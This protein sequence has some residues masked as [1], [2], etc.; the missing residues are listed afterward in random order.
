MN[1][2]RLQLD[3]NNSKSKE[4]KRKYAQLQDSKHHLDAELVA[5]RSQMST[6]RSSLDATQKI[7]AERDKQL[8]ILNKELSI[9]RLQLAE[10]KEEARKVREHSR[11]VEE[12]Q[13]MELDSMQQALDKSFANQES[14]RDE[15]ITKVDSSHSEGDNS[16]QV[17]SVDTSSMTIGIQTR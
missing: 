3:E 4:L 2:L 17:D 1:D 7:L 15:L 14:L 13:A 16:S 10:I 9:S 8:E 12:R 5:L 11:I 6:E